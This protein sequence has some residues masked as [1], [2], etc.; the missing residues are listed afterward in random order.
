MEG[1]CRFCGTRGKLHRSHIFPRW[2]YRRLHQFGTGGAVASSAPLL[3]VE[4]DDARY[5]DAQPREYLLCNMCER[6]F[7]VWEE[8]VSGLAVQHDGRFPALNLVRLHGPFEADKECAAVGA[9][10][11]AELGYFA[12]SICWRASVGA[13]YPDVNLGPYEGAF[14]R[15]LDGSDGAL[16][17]SRLVVQVIDRRLGLEVER[18]G[19][20]PYSFREGGCW[21]HQFAVPGFIFTFRVG[22]RLP[23]RWDEFCFLRR[24]RVWVIDGSEMG[25]T[26][27]SKLAAV[28]PQRSRRQR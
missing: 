6:R 15:F 18:V 11:G 26:V 19:A 17:C 28:G 25:R 21:R 10:V 4:G 2:V 7:G 27:A 20:P 23:A 22:Q 12:A 16:E 13:T 1:V 24:R 3:Q 8:H 14:K 5:S 9:A